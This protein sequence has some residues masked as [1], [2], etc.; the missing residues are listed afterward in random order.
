MSETHVNALGEEW[1]FLEQLVF[2][3]ASGNEA[4]V[5]RAAGDVYKTDVPSERAAV[6]Y[7]LERALLDI[8]A[9]YPRN[10]VDRTVEENAHVGNIIDLAGRVSQEVGR[11]LAGDNG[12]TVG[13]AQKALNLYLKYLWCAGRKLE[14]PHCP[15][16][17]KVV[18]KLNKLKK[19]PPGFESWTAIADKDKYCELVKEA[20]DRMIMLT[21]DQDIKPE[22]LAVWELREWNSDQLRPSKQYW[23]SKSA[24]IAEG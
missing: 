3:S 4:L 10:T 9:L 11:F 20:R 12:L 18:K 14:P 13:R 19:L 24:P 5:G 21:D 2:A 22:S 16:D 8:S 23:A 7:E 17:G 15:F 6:H 1:K